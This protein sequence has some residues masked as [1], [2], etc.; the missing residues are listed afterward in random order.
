MR[1]KT[2]ILSS[3]FAPPARAGDAA[4]AQNVEPVEKISPHAAGR[5]PEA[6]ATVKPVVALKA[7]TRRSGAAQEAAQ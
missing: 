5:P 1:A 7:A 4:L 6:F 2:A 3:T